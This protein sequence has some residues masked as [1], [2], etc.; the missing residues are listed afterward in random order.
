MEVYF[1]ESD[2]S[3][4]ASDQNSSEN[5]SENF[6]ENDL[7]SQG[8]ELRAVTTTEELDNALDEIAK[9]LENSFDQ[10]DLQI[11][12]SFISH[13]FVDI[14]I[15]VYNQINRYVPEAS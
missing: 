14:C 8:L 15:Q 4:N 2:F 12:V 5:S 7:N 11:K 9:D 3:T 1:D 6:N 13:F 10:N